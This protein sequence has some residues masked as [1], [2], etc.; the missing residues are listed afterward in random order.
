[1]G[2][3][4]TAAFSGQRAGSYFPTASAPGCTGDLAKR[5]EEEVNR[6]LLQS[7]RLPGCVW[8]SHLLSQWEEGQSLAEY[9]L[10]LALIAIVA[11]GTLQLLGGKLVLIL[12]RIANTM[13][14]SAH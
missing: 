14:A 12:D 1:M 3:L 6:N 5:I 8:L 9:A 13:V 4:P 7:D 2:I 11:I 10:I